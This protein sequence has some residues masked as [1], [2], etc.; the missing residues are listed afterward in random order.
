MTEEWEY[1]EE[2]IAYQQAKEYLNSCP[3]ICRNCRWLD[4]YYELGCTQLAYPVGN[5]CVL[6][7]HRKWF[8]L[9]WLWKKYDL[10][11]F[12]WQAKVWFCENVLRMKRNM[13][14]SWKQWEYYDDSNWEAE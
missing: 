10:H 1:I 5:K 4:S 6:Y 3:T 14:G 7:T 12:L 2:A 11:Y 13:V 9:L 8:K